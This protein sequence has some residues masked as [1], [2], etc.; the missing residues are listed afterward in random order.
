VIEGIAVQLKSQELKE[1]LVK[2]IAHHS[3]RAKFYRVEEEKFEKEAKDAE[4]RQG[5]NTMVNTHKAMCDSASQHERAAVYFQFLV[6][7]LIPDEVYRLDTKDLSIIEATD[8][9]GYW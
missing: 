3:S 1:H 8:V 6:D 9:R 7:H 4:I 5:Q 2:R